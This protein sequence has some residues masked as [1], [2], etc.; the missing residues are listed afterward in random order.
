VVLDCGGGW[1][2]A[3]SGEEEIG[4]DV[5]VDEGENGEDGG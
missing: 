4:A 1:V 5:G 3:V 2:L